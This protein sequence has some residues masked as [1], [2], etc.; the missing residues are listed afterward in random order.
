MYLWPT[1]LCKQLWDLLPQPWPLSW[2]QEPN[3]QHPAEHHQ[4]YVPN[5]LKNCPLLWKVTLW[6]ASSHLMALPY[7]QPPRPSNLSY[8]AAPCPFLKSHSLPSFFLSAP[9]ASVQIFP[10]PNMDYWNSF[11]MGFP[12]SNYWSSLSEYLTVSVI[13]FLYH[14]PKIFASSSLSPQ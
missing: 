1:P 4:M 11:I 9:T 2:P 14:S 5:W 3:V 7:S 6:Q 8:L 13:S 12:A 10:V